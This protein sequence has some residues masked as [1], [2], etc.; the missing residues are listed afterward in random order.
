MEEK[1]TKFRKEIDEIDEKIL[2]LLEER[3]DVVSKIGKAKSK[4]GV[5]AYDPVREQ[6][7]LERLAKKS[8]LDDGFVRD[9]YRTIIKQCRSGEKVQPKPKTQS[10]KSLDGSCAVLGPA[11]T[12]TETAAKQLFEKQD[13]KYESNVEEVF[14]VVESSQVE[15]GVVAL[16]NSLEGSVGKTM[17]GLLNYGVSI[18]G[19]VTLPINLAL[20]GSKNPTTILSHPHALAQC[21]RYL[22]E[23]Y[24]VATL[25]SSDSTAQAL[26]E[27]KD[28]E[29]AA[30]IGPVEAAKAMG[31]T[32]VEENIQ[33]DVSETR[34]VAIS[35][36]PSEG[37]KTSVIFALGDQ[38]GA[39]HNALKVFADNR[40][41]LSKIESRPS[42][43]KL[44]EYLFF[45]D[46]EN[47]N[48]DVNK[49]LGE[50]KENTTY[51]KVLGSY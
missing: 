48:L 41:N 4:E 14:K 29:N 6:K 23:K 1:L 37:G 38:P 40:V 46:F 25:V 49:I 8:K 50:L 2:S 47:K 34:F 33:D 22:I 44:G 16:E 19:E 3:V 10:V 30:A 20:S 7:I 15:Y 51:L 24:P 12:F 18:V 13:F 5:G 11:G 36:T 35:K 9:I 42:R 32:V 31:L 39:L 26:S 43:R 28:V 45:M 27:V 21:Q 17:E